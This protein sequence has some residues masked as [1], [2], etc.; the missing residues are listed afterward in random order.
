MTQIYLVVYG[1]TLRANFKDCSGQFERVERATADAEWPYDVGDDPSFF[2]ARRNGLLTWGVCRQ[3]VRTAIHRHTANGEPSVVVFFSFTKAV[4]REPMHYRLSAVATVAE[5][6]DRRDVFRD[7]RFRGRTDEYLNLLIRPQCDGWEYDESYRP[8]RERHYDWLWRIAAHEGLSQKAFTQKYRRIYEKLWF[9]DGAVA[10]QRN[11]IIFSS[12]PDETYIASNPPEVATAVPG[13]HEHWHRHHYLSQLK[14]LTVDQARELH[15]AGRNFLRSTNVQRAHPQ[16]RFEM[17]ED[18]ALSW[19]R[20]LISCL[21]SAHA[22]G[23]HA[24]I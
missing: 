3:D 4:R 6:V 5:T 24:Q 7:S 17:P 13:K 10:M 2:V 1:S 15:C 16:I 9:P 21:R 11:Y 8:K 22:T 19:R 23:M 20:S 12:S 14:Q 18:A